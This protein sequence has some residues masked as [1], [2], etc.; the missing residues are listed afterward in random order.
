MSVGKSY[1]YHLVTFLNVDGYDTVCSR[2][3]IGLKQG[4]LDKSVLCGE[5]YIMAVDELLVVETAQTQECIDAVVAFDIEEVL[6]RSALAALVSFRNLVALQ[7]VATSLLG[8]EH[9]GVVHCG[10]ID[11]LCEVLLSAMGSLATHSTS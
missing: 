5:H 2:T 4:L 7:P 10:W 8:E 6:Y 11:E 3:A 9:H 1:S